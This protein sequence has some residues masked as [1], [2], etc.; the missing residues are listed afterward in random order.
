MP[1]FFS[2]EAN[3]IDSIKKK[4]YK[5]KTLKH[6]DKMFIYNLKTIKPS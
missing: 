2:Y 6:K 1:I 5:I 4:S 3:N